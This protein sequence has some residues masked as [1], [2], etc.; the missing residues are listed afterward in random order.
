MDA[1]SKQ[2]RHKDNNC[3]GGDKIRPE[4]K[5]DGVPEN[6]ITAFPCSADQATKL[7]CMKT[8][9]PSKEAKHACLEI[10][11]PSKGTEHAYMEGLYAYKETKL[12]YMKA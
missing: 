6:Q 8:K 7:A 9:H 1:D 3:S 2:R 12:T 10:K 5:L 11:H 4:L